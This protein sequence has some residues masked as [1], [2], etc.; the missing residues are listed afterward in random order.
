[1]ELN[2]QYILFIYICEIYTSLLVCLYCANLTVLK[3][4]YGVLMIRLGVRFLKSEF[5]SYFVRE[6]RC[7]TL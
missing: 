3:I 2:A 1:M 7:L 6:F 5:N 4:K